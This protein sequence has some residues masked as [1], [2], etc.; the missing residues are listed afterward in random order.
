[1][2]D[3]RAQARELEH[4]VVADRRQPPG[5]RQHAWV[6]RVDPVDVGVDLAEVGV[7]HGGERHGGRIGAAAAERGDVAV[8]VDALES[9]GDHDRA[10]V[11]QFLHVVG[12]DR[13][14]ACLRM[15]AIGADADLGTGEADGL[16]PERL[17]RHREKGHAHLLAR[18]EEHVHLAGAG[19][20]GDL[21]G[22]VDEHVGLV[23]HRADHDHH[24][25]ARLLPRD[26]LLRRRQDLLRISYARPA[27]LLHHECHRHCLPAPFR[28]REC[29]R[30]MSARIHASLDDA[31]PYPTSSVKTPPSACSPAGSTRRRLPPRTRRRSAGRSAGCRC[32]PSR[33]ARGHGNGSSSR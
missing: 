24:L 8:L 15:G 9:G 29:L 12:R 21:F 25:M 13:L 30:C 33:T 28:R 23:A 20:V 22:K 16:V 26:R 31:I 32:L 18:R 10:V 4:L 7:E 6:G 2:H 1:M 27:K 11:E 14:D 3:A 5:L 17:D 19:P